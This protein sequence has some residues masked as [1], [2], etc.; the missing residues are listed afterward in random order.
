MLHQLEIENYAVIE[1]LRVS[2]HAGLNLLT[3]ETGSGKSIL[4]DALSL[5]LGGKASAELVRAGEERARM[6]GVFEISSPPEGLDLEQG[7]LLVEREILANGKSR[8]YLNGRL[9][10]LAAL[11]EL[12][13]ALGD[14]HGQHE[15]QD[16]FSPQT[17]LEML[18]EFCGASDL[19]Q[20]AG[21][22]FAQW[23]QAGARLDALR[24]NEQEKLRLLDLWKFQE[25]EIG[26]AKLRPGEDAELEQEE[27]VLA[28]LSRIQQGG[29]TAYEALYES[30]DA[31]VSQ[32]KRAIRALEDLSRFD[33]RFASLAQAIGGA[34]ISLEEAAIELRDQL[35]RLE[36]NPERLSE[37]EDRLA[38]IEKLKRK[39]GST[40]DEILAFGEQVAARLAELESSEEAIRSAQKDQAELAAQYSKIAAEL[41]QRRREGAKRL[42]KPVERELA[43]LAME[44]T[45]FAVVFEDGSDGPEAWTQHGI[46]RVQFLVSPNPGEPLRSLELV[47]SGGELSRITLAIKTCLAGASSGGNSVPRTLVF[48]EIDAGIDGRAAEAVGR[49]LQ[50][51]SRSYQLLCVTHLPQIAGFAGHHYAVDKQL[52]AGRTI[53]TVTELKGEDR[54]RELARMLS[55]AQVT[56]DAMRHAQ[57]L[58]EAGRS[59]ARGA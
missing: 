51:L 33:A 43:A 54:V 24:V 1:R 19:R 55:G 11:R 41:S 17:Q 30:P 16:L 25:Q 37:V 53:T 59:E 18:D 23:K 9:V 58:L 20:R 21:D 7:E 34:G 44:R 15:Q 14:I 22:L 31:A 52:K 39:Y 47:A 45:R 4:V 36:A 5:L 57:Q 3:G 42:E 35:D 8:A 28:N 32:A 29:A 56:A 27:R 13:P 50:G 6:A 38:L 49:R 26:Q 2:F 40:V 46:D 48:D 10:T 12:A